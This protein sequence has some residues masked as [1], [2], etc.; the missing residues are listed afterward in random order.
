ME[1]EREYETMPKLVTISM[2]EYKNLLIIKGKYEELKEQ[3]TPKLIYGG[4]NENGTT[5]LPCRDIQ[6]TDPILN[7]PFKITCKK[8]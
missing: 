2:E 5:I 7:P 1:I 3:K 4:F 8:E 6:T